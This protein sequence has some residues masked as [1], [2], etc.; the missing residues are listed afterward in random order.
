MPFS[1][2][3]FIKGENTTSNL[4]LNGFVS[5]LCRLLG[6]ICLGQEERYPRGEGDQSVDGRAPTW[7]K[8]NLQ[9]DEPWHALR[10]ASLEM[11]LIKA[12]SSVLHCSLFQIDRIRDHAFD[13]IRYA[14]DIML[15][16]STLKTMERTSIELH[17]TAGSM[18]RNGISRE[19]RQNWISY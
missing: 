10:A 17:C 19:W 7:F 2:N 3:S 8:D 11:A 18:F 13:I 12:R 9:I 6:S 4:M 15:Q 14:D 16:C 5:Y 1:L